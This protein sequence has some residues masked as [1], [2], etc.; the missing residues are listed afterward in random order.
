MTVQSSNSGSVSG[1]DG[2]WQNKMNDSSAQQGMKRWI[3]CT[4]FCMWSDIVLLE[5][6]HRL[7]KSNYTVNF[8]ANIKVLLCFVFFFRECNWYAESREKMESYKIQ[9]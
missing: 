6:G 7:V 4:L 2:I 1:D 3:G 8:R 9:N 5:G